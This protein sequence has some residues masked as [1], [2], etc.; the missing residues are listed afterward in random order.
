MTSATG[1]GIATTDI[2]FVQ[3]P[4]FVTLSLSDLAIPADG[5]SSATV[6]VNVQ[7]ANGYPIADGFFVNFSTTAGKLGALTTTTTGGIA[8]TTIDSDTILRDGNP[9]PLVRITAET[10]GVSNWTELA[11]SP[12]PPVSINVDSSPTTIEANGYSTSTVTAFLYDA[13]GTPVK[14]GLNVTFSVLTSIGVKFPSGT[15]ISNPVPTVN[16]AAAV[17]LTAGIIAAAK[18]YI[19]ATIGGVFKDYSGL[20]LVADSTSPAIS[21]TSPSD[22]AIDVPFNSDITVKFNEPI[23]SATLNATNIRVFENSTTTAPLSMIT[24]YDAA[25]YTLTINPPD[26]TEGA[27]IITILG[28]GIQDNFGNPLSPYVFSF[29]VQ[30]ITVGVPANITLAVDRTLVSA[31]DSEVAIITATVKDTNGTL[32]P[33]GKI[34]NFATDLGS[35][36][37]T[38]L[39]LGSGA[40]ATVGGIAKAS[41]RSSQKGTATITVTSATGS[42]IA[43]TDITF[44][45]PPVYLTLSLGSTAIAADGIDNTTITATVQDAN[46][47]PIADG[48]FVNYSTSAGKLGS[49]TVSTLNGVAVTT[50]TSDTILRDGVVNP[51][52]TITASTGGITNNTEVAFSPG[53]PT[54]ISVGASPSTITAN[55]VDTSVISATVLDQSGQ[56]VKDGLFVTFTIHSSIYGTF[57]NGTRVS[58]PVPTANGIASV[59]M[60]AGNTGGTPII[61]GTIGQ[62]SDI[63][64]GLL[65]NDDLISPTASPVSPIDGETGVAKGTNVVV[66]FNEPIDQTTLTTSNFKVSV[67]GVPVAGAITYVYNPVTKKATATFNPASDF[68]DGVVVT[69]EL[70]N[71]ITD[72]KPNPLNPLIYTFST[73][74]SGAG[75]PASIS[76]VSD[77][78]KVSTAST[79]TLTATVKDLFSNNV[80]DG[81]PVVFTSNKVDTVFGSATSLTASGL[82]TTTV[83][84]PT[85]GTATITATAGTVSNTVVVEFIE[86][87][88]EVAVWALDSTIPADG[89]TTTTLTAYI[90]DQY[91]NAVVDGLN[92]QFTVDAGTLNPPTGLVQTTGGGLATVTITSTTAYTPIVNITAVSEAITGTNTMSFSPG[93]PVT[94]GILATPNLI[95]ANGTDTTTIIAYIQDTIGQPVKDGMMATFSVVSSSYGKFPNGGAISN[96]VLTSGGFITTTLTA[97]TKDGN[98]PITVDIGNLSVSSSPL[99][100]DP[101]NTPPQVVSQNPAPLTI[102]VARSASLAVAFNEPMDKAT[103][104]SGTTFTVVGSLSGSHTGFIIYDTT[105]NKVTFYPYVSFSN[106]EDVTVTL[107]TAITDVAGNPLTNTQWT[108]RTIDNVPPAAPTGFVGQPGNTEA[109][110]A[111]NANAEPDVAGYNLKMSLSSGGPYTQVIGSIA[112]TSITHTG[113]TNG[114]TY[115]YVLEAVDTTGNKSPY[116]SEVTVIPS[117]EVAPAIP[118][119]FT[120]TAGDSVVFLNWSA[121]TESDLDGYNVFMGTTFGFYSTGVTPLNGGTLIPVGTTSYTAPAINGVTWYFVMTAVDT[122]PLESLPAPVVSAVPEA[123]PDPPHGVT[124]TSGAGQIFLNWSTPTLNSDG[125]PL[126]DRAGY[127]VYMGTAAGFDSTAVAPSNAS[128]IPDGTTFFNVTGL[129]SG[130]YYFV[131]KTVDNSA[132]LSAASTEVNADSGD[133]PVAPTGLVLIE[134]NQQVNLT[135]NEN[136]EANVSSYNIYQSTAPG[137]YVPGVTIPVANVLSGAGATITKDIFS[138]SNLNQYYFVVTAINSLGLESPA[139]TEVMGWP[140]WNIADIDHDNIVGGNDLTLLGLAYANDSTGPSWN[141]ESDLNGDGFIDLGDLI[142]LRQYFGFTGP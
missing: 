39:D 14:D 134:G 7:D 102:G 9:T 16:G 37:V 25:T 47:Y 57:P 76:V 73:E 31:D 109:L 114:S 72:N 129:A 17:P 4:V 68:G 34:I 127:N 138:L 131:V 95:E 103:I 100:I 77:K 61:T 107:T 120:A 81:T 115:Y 32:V 97:G 123:I 110:F 8:T 64:N 139:S 101:D 92:V 132:L 45:Q 133:A 20:S 117:S 21:G 141:P 55:T 78:L 40:G 22:Q 87:P 2:T 29:D 23:D 49:G 121:N 33:D 93:P 136:S 106:D 36:T 28:S 82:A 26:F 90:S 67:A 46:G 11:F 137:F 85:L 56:T 60:T 42:G 118:S 38:L 83:S 128:L 125:S 112:T 18:P 52:V 6:T 63:Y 88:A 44:V 119:G 24:N 10:G 5:T 104:V 58:N 94:V 105:L 80:P 124:A 79:A 89:T 135:W 108:F 111:W 96:P 122:V 99:T 35:S 62:Y 98:P 84:A 91:G 86:P 113:L 15:A 13:S 59:T 71:L 74:I 1:S 53:P 12:G 130:T 30:T 51:V 19:R 50:I 54:S 142:I 48:F 43:T 3:P 75:V 41:V 27:N 70:T 126:T 116:S 140:Q 69:V 66:E 65:L